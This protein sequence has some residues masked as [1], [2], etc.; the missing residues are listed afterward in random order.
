MRPFVFPCVTAQ[1][2]SPW[3]CLV[4]CCL[5][6]L[7]SLSCVASAPCQRAFCRNDFCMTHEA[8]RHMPV[9]HQHQ[10]KDNRQRWPGWSSQEH[11]VSWTSNRTLEAELWETVASG[12]S[13]LH[14]GK[15]GVL[16]EALH[17]SGSAAP[18][19]LPPGIWILKMAR[20]MMQMASAEYTEC[21][22][23]WSVYKLA[24]WDLIYGI[25]SMR[26]PTLC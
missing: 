26:Q 16:T 5:E 15:H 18:R 13:P 2:G 22:I 3:S 21:S 17:T 10:W 4:S 20:I 7:A 24:H 11:S 12:S 1:K 25:K 14:G 8:R 19:F 9:I 23:S 6:T